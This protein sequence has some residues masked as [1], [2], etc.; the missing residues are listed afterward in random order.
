MTKFIIREYRD[1]EKQNETVDPDLAKH[2]KNFFIN[3]ILGKRFDQEFIDDIDYIISSNYVPNLSYSKDAEFHKLEP[4][5][6][7]KIKLNGYY[8]IHQTYS[9]TRQFLNEY[10]R[11]VKTY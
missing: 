2:R 1:K 6:L 7:R 5:H 11:T 10:T 3:R 8:L 9:T 4:K